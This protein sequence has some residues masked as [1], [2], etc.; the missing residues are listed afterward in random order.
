MPLPNN[1]SA[2]EHARRVGIFPP[3]QQS[4]QQSNQQPAAA[5]PA[6]Q[7]PPFARLLSQQHRQ[8][9]PRAPL[10]PP[11]P[12]PPASELGRLIDRKSKKASATGTVKRD[13]G[14]KFLLRENRVDNGGKKG[15]S[16][17]KLQRSL[18][19][20]VSF[21]L[22][23]RAL[24]PPPLLSLSYSRLLSR[25]NAPKTKTKRTTE[26]SLSNIRAERAALASQLSALS[27]APLPQARARLA[28]ARARFESAA[29]AQKCLELELETKTRSQTAELR[30][31][32]AGL[33]ARRAEAGAALRGAAEGHAAAMA[34]A[35]EAVEE[36][37]GRAG[38]AFLADG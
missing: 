20:S 2:A 33:A 22:S 7:Q 5:A 21:F 10:R 17:R 29:A 37:T 15:L 31:V 3:L 36:A 28:A 8:Q 27:A 25:S 1:E 34:A 30:A 14:K 4:Q 11:P 35:F 13:G 6:A 23:P 9:H 38:G 12:P 32:A 26:A 18:V 19:L 24:D 16:K